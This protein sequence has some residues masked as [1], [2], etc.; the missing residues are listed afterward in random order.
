MSK[1]DLKLARDVDQIDSH[2]TWVQNGT[3][4]GKIN[5][6]HTG[7]KGISDLELPKTAQKE[8]AGQ[9]NLTPCVST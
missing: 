5:K 6:A 9:K 3:V 4:I 2:D 1:P 8:R 7:K